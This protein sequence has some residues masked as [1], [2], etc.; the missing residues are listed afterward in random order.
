MSAGVVASAPPA[1]DGPPPH[2][3]PVRPRADHRPSRVTLLGRQVEL[4][5]LTSRLLCSEGGSILVT[6]YRGVGET[7]FVNQVIR[8]LHEALPEA[9]PLRGRTE[10]LDVQS[11]RYPGSAQPSIRRAVCGWSRT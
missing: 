8:L 5:A 10:L 1:G 9:E 3:L 7:S 2:G 6:G 11:R 4:N